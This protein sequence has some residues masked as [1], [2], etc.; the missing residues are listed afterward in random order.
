MEED[1]AHR[2]FPI[3]QVPSGDAG[4]ISAYA[5]CEVC[6][7]ALYKAHFEKAAPAPFATPP[8]LYVRLLPTKA[9][10]SLRSRVDA[11]E[12]FGA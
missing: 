4:S 1:G 11:G 9:R 8:G 12:A 5:H 3:I 10:E 6:Q 2:N 7:L